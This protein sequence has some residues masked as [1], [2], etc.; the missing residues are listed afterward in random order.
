M[1]GSKPTV[2]VRRRWFL[3]A[4]VALAAT[5]IPFA[6]AY[7]NFPFINIWSEAYGGNWRAFSDVDLTATA[8]I[9]KGHV[10]SSIDSADPPWAYA[11]NTSYFDSSY[12]IHIDC[13][14]P[15]ETV[16][17]STIHE[18]LWSV[19]SDYQEE[20]TDDLDC[21]NVNAFE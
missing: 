12:P 19:S 20:S 8:I 16:Y 10:E 5:S 14:D 6:K 15:D 7:A 18:V 2:H 3:M 13:V 11:Y 1:L 17:T 4:I 9:H 21:R